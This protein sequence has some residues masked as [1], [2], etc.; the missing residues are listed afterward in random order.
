MVNDDSDDPFALVRGRKIRLR[1]SRSLCA[2]CCLLVWPLGPSSKD[3]E[4]WSRGLV[5]RFDV[6]MWIK[7]LVVEAIQGR[8]IYVVVD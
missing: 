8:V 6:P 1:L 4:K 2:E 3:Q 7:M 5:T